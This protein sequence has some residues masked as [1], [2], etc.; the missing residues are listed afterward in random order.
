MKASKRVYLY[1]AFA[2]IFVAL[3][4]S[5]I[6]LLI[7]NR[8]TA[9][10]GATQEG[11]AFVR[12]DV[13]YCN[14]QNKSQEYDLF[15]PVSSS[16]KPTPLVVHVHGGGWSEGSKST[17]VADHYAQPLTE[18]G[19][20]FAS[21][22]YRLADEA[23]YPAQNEDVQC[24]IE[25]IQQRSDDLNIDAQNIIIMGDSAGGHLAALEGLD[26]TN[27]HI[28][29]VIMLYGVSDLWTQITKYKDTNAIHYL[30]ER[31][32]ELAKQ[33]S[34]LYQDLSD[35]PPFLLVHGTKDTVVPA[36]ESERFAKQLKASG[37]TATYV[38]IEG[39][40]HAFEDNDK[41]Y[42]SQSRPAVMDFIEKQFS[43]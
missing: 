25:H 22:D 23:I 10:A 8:T 37:R 16:E 39:A 18:K 21:I 14:T 31:N 28:K 26:A 35:A 30:G 27:D 7:I 24:A 17:G 42:E 11:S 13:K 2:F 3:L 1:G 15:T 19:I 20:A 36:S 5:L 9:P 6:S 41:K 29:A 4:A 38:P 12:R 32:E 40:S 34:P 33:A 43:N